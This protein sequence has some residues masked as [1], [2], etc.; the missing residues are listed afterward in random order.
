MLFRSLA[1]ADDTNPVATARLLDSGKIGRMAVL[2]KWRHRGI[3]T[4]LLSHLINEAT[5]RGLEQVY[6]SPHRSL[7]S[8]FTS[9]WALLFAAI[10][11]QMQISR[12]KICN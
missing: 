11:I 8:R 4:A 9:A 6:L 1:F 3:G 10:P 12:I 5:E 7:P 2:R